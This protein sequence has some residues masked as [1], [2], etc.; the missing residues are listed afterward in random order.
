MLAFDAELRRAV[1]NI[2]KGRA[3]K[4]PAAP[5]STAN[6]SESVKRILKLPV[7]I[8]VVPGREADNVRERD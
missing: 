7:P 5:V 4:K 2:L 8:I 3:G 1:E 6:L